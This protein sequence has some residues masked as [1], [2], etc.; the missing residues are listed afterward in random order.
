MRIYVK[1]KL[2]VVFAKWNFPRYSQR[3]NP[4]IATKQAALCAIS[5][6]SGQHGAIE[7]IAA[8][9]GRALSQIFTKLSE[10]KTNIC[11]L[12]FKMPL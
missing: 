8:K 7:N 9:S 11:A 1:C 12:I 5:Q 6:R 2:R 10:D 3:V 4:S